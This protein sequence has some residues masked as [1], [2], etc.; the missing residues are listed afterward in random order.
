MAFQPHNRHAACRCGFTVHMECY[1]DWLNSSDMAYN[2]IICHKTVSYTELA[3]MLEEME[4]TAEMFRRA[5]LRAAFEEQ[6][7]A[8]FEARLLKEEQAAFKVRRAKYVATGCAMACALG[9]VEGLP[10]ALL[11]GAIW[12]VPVVQDALSVCL[13]LPV[14]G[15]HISSS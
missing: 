6:L 1:N 2:C 13:G 7:K 10:F 4:R 12:A 3:I 14:P 5:R 15:Y 11:V 9:F 8:A